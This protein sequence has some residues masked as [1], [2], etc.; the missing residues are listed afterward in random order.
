MSSDQVTPFIEPPSNG[1]IIAGIEQVRS[2]SVLPNIMGSL[3]RMAR[4]A[5][6]RQ[7]RI[8]Q[9]SSEFAVDWYDSASR[10]GTLN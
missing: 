4:F 7:G 8:S 9:V 1:A 2:T 10:L 6:V 3:A 5:D